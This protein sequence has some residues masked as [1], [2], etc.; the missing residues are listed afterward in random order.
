MGYPGRPAFTMGK[1]GVNPQQVS[2]E[3]NRE[4]GLFQGLP[5]RPHLKGLSGLHPTAGRT[6]HP[7][8]IVGLPDDREPGR[9]VQGRVGRMPDEQRHVVAAVFAR[10][11][12]QEPERVGAE[13]R[14]RHGY[15]R[16]AIAGFHLIQHV[17][18]Q[19]HQDE[20]NP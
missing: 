3:A 16:A 6:K 12:F 13:L 11:V 14:L 15:H 10:A 20:F 5:G 19:V 2:L 18:G 4:P 17:P 7:S 1:L 9:G 8:G